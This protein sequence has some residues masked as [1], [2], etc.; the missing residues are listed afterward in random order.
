MKV[1]HQNPK[2]NKIKKKAFNGVNETCKKALPCQDMV[3]RTEDR[4]IY[5]FRETKAVLCMI[6]WSV[7]PPFSSIRK[8]IKN[9]KII[10]FPRVTSFLH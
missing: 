8:K 1:G 4:L 6:A 3:R 10:Q 7:G 9:K 2:E 5:M